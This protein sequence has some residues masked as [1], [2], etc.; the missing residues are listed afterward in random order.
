MFRRLLNL[1]RYEL[2]DKWGRDFVV[3][4]VYFVGEQDGPIERELKTQWKIILGL[5][6]D[7]SAAYLANVIYG[8][9]P[10]EHVVLCLRS[11]AAKNRNLEDQ[12]SASFV[13]RFNTAESLDIMYITAEEE[14]AVQRVCRPLHIA[15]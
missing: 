1:L 3:P 2:F 7:I 15:A 6:P 10:S 4:G 13:A 11:T 14:L 12:L 9:N 5:T 8:S